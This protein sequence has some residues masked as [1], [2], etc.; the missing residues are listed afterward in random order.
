MKSSRRKHR[1][2]MSILIPILVVTVIVAAVIGFLFINKVTVTQ[3]RTEDTVELGNSYSGTVADYM[4]ASREKAL[5]DMTI[6][7]SVV[8]TSAAGDYSVPITYKDR[9]TA[10][11][12]TAK[13]GLSYDAGTM[14]AVAD[15]VDVS[16]AE[17]YTVNFIKDGS[18][19]S[20]VS[21]NEPGETSLTVQATDAAGNKSD[22]VQVPVTIRSVDVT[23]PVISGAEDLE[24]DM[25]GD[26]PDYLDGV[27]ASDDTDGDITSSISVDNSGV[28][29]SKAAK[30]KVTYSVSDAA[31]NV[32]SNSI[33]LTVVD[34]EAEEK[35]AADKKAKEEA[36]AKEEA[37]KAAKEAAAAAAKV[38][39][40]TAAS[41]SSNTAA[42]A[43]ATTATPAATVAASSG[44]PSWVVPTNGV[45]QAGAQTIYNYWKNKGYTDA[46][47]QSYWG[48]LT[49]H[50]SA[51]GTSGW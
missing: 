19:V 32:S 48:A 17:Q 9:T 20:S 40:A 34:K 30:Y 10:P 11:V 3:T 47:I 33:T 4:T 16:D 28:D 21:I 41:A 37:E 15:V 14:I 12:I 22:E 38:A 39:A 27:S 44:Y 35:A 2:R 29:M 13:S 23:A 1:T 46:Q 51:H 5:A 25:D 31:G 50:Y 45:D 26:E 43:A 18:P 42:S 36:A 6:D 8:N 49:T 7:T 24:A